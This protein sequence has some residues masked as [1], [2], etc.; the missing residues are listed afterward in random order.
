M[1]NNLSASKILLPHAP[2][3]EIAAIKGCWSFQHESSDPFVIDVGWLEE[4][5]EEDPETDPDSSKEAIAIMALL[6]ALPQCDGWR[7]MD[8]LYLWPA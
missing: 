4:Q 5:A 6:D 7:D 3:R 1:K 8:L 2:L